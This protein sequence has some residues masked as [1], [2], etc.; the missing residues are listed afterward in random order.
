MRIV[1]TGVLDDGPDRAPGVPP[2]PRTPLSWQTG[3]SVTIQLFGI[4]K[5]TGQPLNFASPGG[6]QVLFEVRLQPLPLA[7]PILLSIVG[8][9]P[10]PTPKGTLEFIVTP[11]AQRNLQAQ[12]IRRCFYDVVLLRADGTRDSLVPTS[13]LYLYPNV[14]KI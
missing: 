7:Q 1:L 5:S 12:S 4:L 9:P 13:P 10:T 3:D 14:T 11:A 2:N 6:Q 8:V